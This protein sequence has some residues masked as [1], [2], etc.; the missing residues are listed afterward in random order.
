MLANNARIMMPSSTLHGNRRQSTAIDGNPMGTSDLDGDD[1]DA[2]HRLPINRHFHEMP[3]QSNLEK[4]MI[5]YGP[6]ADGSRGGGRKS[7]SRDWG[8]G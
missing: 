1:H 7:T 6:P 5:N 4:E 2:T 8:A 3:N